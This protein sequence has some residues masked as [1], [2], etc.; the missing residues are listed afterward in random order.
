MLSEV[1]TRKVISNGGWSPRGECRI[2][3]DNP[4]RNFR[5]RGKV[6][7]MVT[8]RFNGSGKK[9]DLKEIPDDQPKIV[10]AIEKALLS[11]W[12]LRCMVIPEVQNSEA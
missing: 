7:E 8:E 3:G 2:S 6:P 11:P 10:A 1:K 9:P 12:F 5:I 4:N